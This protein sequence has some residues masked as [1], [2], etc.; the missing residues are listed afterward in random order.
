MLTLVDFGTGP[1][2]S[3]F[4]DVGTERVKPEFVRFSIWVYMLMFIDVCFVSAIA[5]TS[6]FQRDHMKM[7][8]MASSGFP[9]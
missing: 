8:L 9:L 7:C 1:L 3:T 2:V 6:E 4:V 5:K